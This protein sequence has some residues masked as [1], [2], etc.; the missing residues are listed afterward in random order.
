MV[1]SP[2]WQG[3]FVGNSF[4]PNTGRSFIYPSGQPLPYDH[5]N[6]VEE[7]VLLPV[8]VGFSA[9]YVQVWAQTIASP[10]VPGGQDFALF[11]ENAY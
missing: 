11:A 4:N 7:V 1:I 3:F 2:A 5:C 6:N 9:F 8:G 10:P